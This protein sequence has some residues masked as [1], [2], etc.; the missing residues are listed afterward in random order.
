MFFNLF[1]QLFISLQIIFQKFL[2]FFKLSNSNVKLVLEHQNQHHPTVLK[3]YV[4]MEDEE[5]GGAVEDAD[6]TRIMKS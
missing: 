1:L 3:A 2:Q 5:P 4:L 6:S